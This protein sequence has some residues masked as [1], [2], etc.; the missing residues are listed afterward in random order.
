MGVLLGYKESV[1][2]VVINMGFIEHFIIHLPIK[3]AYT[4]FNKFSKIPE[5]FLQHLHL[6][7]FPSFY[8]YIHPGPPDHFI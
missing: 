2:S 4:T 3:F 7:P 6:I 8:A 1:Y 5:I